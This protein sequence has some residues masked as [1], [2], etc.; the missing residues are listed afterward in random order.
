M[1]IS[2]ITGFNSQI[3]FARKTNTETA[4]TQVANKWPHGKSQHITRQEF[5]E[6]LSSN[7]EGRVFI[8]NKPFTGYVERTTGGNGSF[9]L[10]QSKFVDGYDQIG[11][12]KTK[13]YIVPKLSEL[14]LIPSQINNL[15]EFS[16]IKWQNFKPTDSEL[17]CEDKTGL[18]VNIITKK[19]FTGIYISQQGSDGYDV[20]QQA[21]FIKNGNECAKGDKLHYNINDL[22]KRNSHPLI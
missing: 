14:D 8:D 18:V 17:I 20:S 1:N 7:N 13:E 22:R 21:I 16:S 19:P 6:K 10:W 12:T 2:R 15:D 11:S 3:N 4:S 5:N 9:T